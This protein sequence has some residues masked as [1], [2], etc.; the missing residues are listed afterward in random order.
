MK[1]Y[2]L[3][4]LLLIS[5]VTKAQ[6]THFSMFHL[7]PLQLNP[8]Y[9]GM[10]HAQMRL[11]ANAR[12]QWSPVL[13]SQAY[14]SYSAGVDF[15]YPLQKDY[16][17]VGLS[18]L[19]D[20]AGTSSFK[21]DNAKLTLAYSKNLSGRKKRFHGLTAGFEAGVTSMGLDI[22]GLRF[23]QQFNASDVFDKNLPAP[24]IQNEYRNLN[25]GDL[26][27][28]LTWITVMP[29]YYSFHIGAAVHHA[30]RPN[31]SF[32]NL[33]TMLPRFTIDFGGEYFIQG[34]KWALL[35]NIVGMKQGKAVEL[36]AGVAL[37]KT[38]KW[39]KSESGYKAVQLGAWLR[40]NNKLDKKILADA[41]ILFARMDYRQYTFGISYDSNISSLRLANATNG[42]YEFAIHYT[43]D[44]VFPKKLSCPSAGC[45]HLK[46]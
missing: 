40:M 12:N 7:A 23:L 36:N 16:I 33:K 19:N 42:S 21:R 22:D 44:N 3:Y 38:L 10:H 32:V 31:V 35:P 11:M 25:F 37:R 18:F 5:T 43:F 20:K 4:I 17:G 30:N 41:L 6:D 39:A 46:W 1:K 34:K 8:A 24:N 13:K 14:N 15:N 26:G 27:V 28:G 29:E 9:T 2:I 45:K